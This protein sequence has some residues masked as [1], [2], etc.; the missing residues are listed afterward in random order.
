MK[1]SRSS[2]GLGSALL[3]ACLCLVSAQSALAQTTPK[4]Y[5]V[6]RQDALLRELNPATGALISSVPMTFSSGSISGAT[7]LAADPTTGTFYALLRLGAFSPEHPGDRNLVT[8][9][10]T[11][12]AVTNIGPVGSAAKLS[13]ADL[14]FDSNGTLY[15]VTGDGSIGQPRTLFTIDKATG[16]TTPYMPLGNGGDGEAIVYNP[17]DRL[18]YHASGVNLTGA[19]PAPAGLVFESINLAT[20][21]TSPRI[22]LTTTTNAAIQEAAAIAYAGGGAF[23]WSSLDFNQSLV[24]RLVR[25]TSAGVVTAIGTANYLVTGLAFAPTVP[26]ITST[27]PAGAIAGSGEFR[28]TVTGTGF[29]SGAT[30]QWNG[31]SRTTNVVSATQ[32][33]ADISAADVATAGTAQVTVVNPAPGGGTS[34]A[35]SF[36]ILGTPPPP[37][38]LTVGFATPQTN[39]THP[40]NQNISFTISVTGSQTGVAD[41][42]VTTGG[43]TVTL[44]PPTLS[45]VI[46]AANVEG[47]DTL[48]VQAR[49]AT[50]AV[51]ATGRI[52]IFLARPYQPIQS[53]PIRVED[54]TCTL[55]EIYE[56]IKFFLGDVPLTSGTPPRQALLAAAADLVAIDLNVFRAFRDNVLS[57]TPAGRYYTNVY[58]RM[59]FS[60]IAIMVREP[61]QAVAI[62]QTV[63]DWT[64]AIRALVNGQGGTVTITPAMAAQVQTMLTNLRRSA[65]GE[66][67]A[68]MD[69]EIAALNPSSWAGMTIGQLL[70]RVESQQ[71]T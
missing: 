66:L 71:R 56:I 65:T 67:A 58:E 3:A 24:F 8:V 23:I 63:Q 68:I 19:I 14:A 44:R 37:V 61:T 4:L 2:F 41:Y 28:L 49:N 13:F 10:V 55:E 43:N 46:T 17:D 54:A 62:Y 57:T 15:G 7:G 59:S 25:V 16:A 50:G 69:T 1:T 35:R 9:N 20:R 18:M 53:S 39:S 30:V 48:T 31:A 51:L 11:T 52:D 33:T 34:A 42:L 36:S 60:L 38:A 29:L 64:P 40:S 6:A 45:G 70:A 5:A 32:L 12:G 22:P 26:T 21:T 47:F 27:T